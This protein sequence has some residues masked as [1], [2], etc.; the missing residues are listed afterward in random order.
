MPHLERSHQPPL[1]LCAEDQEDLRTDIC[2]ELREAGYAVLEASDGEATLQ[3]IE[4]SAPDLILCDINMPGLNGYDVLKEVRERRPY[5]ADTPFIFLTAL[6]DPRDIVDGK[7]CGAD[8]YLVKPIDFDLLLATVEARLRQVRRMRAKSNHELQELRQAMAGLRHEASRQAFR[9]A[10]RAL[11]LV[12]PGMVLIDGQGHVTFANQRA[13]RLIE[14]A[15]ALLLN[16][17]LSAR[18]SESRPLRKAIADASQAS[19]RGEEPVYSL[20]LPH[21]PGDHGLLVM[22]CAMGLGA[23]AEQD[24]T[25]VVVLLSAPDQRPPLPEGVLASLFGLTPTETRIAMALLEGLRTEEIAA[26][27]GI[28]PTTVAFHLRNLFQ[29]TETHRQADLIALL[30]AGSMTACLEGR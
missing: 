19:Q 10:T 24:D 27:M 29:K 18:G 12:A 23:S 28:S 9:S 2:E 30:L 5:L 16:D 17:T 14:E 15:D 4:A 22:V 13:H 25:S 1:I 7:R 3:Q 26:R 6:S 20:R 21:R 8:D 11:D